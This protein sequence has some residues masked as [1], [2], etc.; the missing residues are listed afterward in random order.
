MVTT[1]A[2]LAIFC[3]T[4]VDDSFIT[5]RY[6]ANFVHGHGPVF[7]IGEKVEGFTSPLHMLVASFTYWLPGGFDLLK[8]KLVSFAITLPAVVLATRLV[9]RFVEREWLARAAVITLAA[10]VPIAAAATNALETSF[11]LL[12]T[13]FLITQAVDGSWSK[14]PWLFGL[15]AAAMQMTRPEAGI[16][17]AAVGLV[18]L[19][20][21]T[22][23]ER[24]ALVKAGAIAAIPVFGYEVFRIAYFGDPLPNTYYAKNVP[25]LKALG[26]GATFVMRA[27]WSEFPDYATPRRAPST[28]AAIINVPIGVVVASLLAF[29]AAVLTKRRAFVLVAAIV[30]QFFF[31]AMSG[32]DW[33]IG[34]FVSPIWPVAIIAFAAAVDFLIERRAALGYV[35]A[36]VVVA[37]TASQWSGTFNPIWRADGLG[38][39][40]LL[41]SGGIARLSKPW[42]DGATF[43]ACARP[44]DLVAY[45]EIGYSGFSRLDV[46]LMDPRGLTDREVAHHAPDDVRKITGVSDDNWRDPNSYMGA[47][48]LRRDPRLII[49]FDGVQGDTALDGKY[50][51]YA[52]YFA[53]SGREIASYRRTDVSCN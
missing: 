28:I 17:I 7:N 30:G 3:A 29:G 2:A 24:I 49:S 51:R 42:A 20:T 47:E 18:L 43:L 9:W 14:R 23:D 16:V 15:T 32:G 13:T 41:A 22:R 12:F 50:I 52:Q 25:V 21:G 44:G 5:L 40:D 34:R 27:L 45:T 39:Y 48:L 33:M 10:S 8:L 6:S 35:A 53:P 11:A 38:D 46:T 31:L 26:F 36:G 37:A 19:A 4:S 1:L